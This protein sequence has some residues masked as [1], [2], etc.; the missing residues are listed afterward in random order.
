MRRHKVHL[1][2]A[3]PKTAHDT[4]KAHYESKLKAHEA[5][6]AA[7]IAAVGAVNGRGSD[8]KKS[9]MSDFYG[10]E[11]GCANK[12][13]DESICLFFAALHLPEHHADHPLWRNV[14]S[15]IQRAGQNYTP[16]KR[17]YIG[18][19]GLAKC[20]QC[21]EVALAPISASWSRVSM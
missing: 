11:A 8:K 16:P 9:R 1:C 21:I 20:H 5:K 2:T 18:G 19:A 7:E 4:V 13:A 17:R 12:A 15:S 3:A 6:R 14:V 10:D